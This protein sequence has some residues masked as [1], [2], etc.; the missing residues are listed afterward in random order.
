V[1]F[2]H[3]FVGGLPRDTT[4]EMLRA[5]FALAGGEVGT[6]EIVQNPATGLPRGFAFVKLLT[7]FDAS[8]D[9]RALERLASTTIDN[10]RLQI[11]GVPIRSRWQALS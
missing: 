5:A 2:D 9:P 1:R 6:I 4:E 3:I 7:P 8:I 11:Q 10:R